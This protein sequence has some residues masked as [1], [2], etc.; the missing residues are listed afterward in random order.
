MNKLLYLVVGGAAHEGGPDVEEHRL[1][2]GQ[3]PFERYNPPH[4]GLRGLRSPQI[5]GCCVTKFA[6]KLISWC[7]LTLDERVVVHRVVGGAEEEG[8]SEVE[9]H[10]LLWCL[11]FRLG[12]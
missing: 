6:L 7:K 3:T 4:G 12:R 10:R 9:E 8:G 2:S 11:G 5:L 1:A